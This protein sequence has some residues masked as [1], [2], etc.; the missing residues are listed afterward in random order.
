MGHQK[1]R[2]AIAKLDFDSLIVA[3]ATYKKINTGSQGLITKLSV[4]QQTF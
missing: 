1:L 2:W 4:E 3:T